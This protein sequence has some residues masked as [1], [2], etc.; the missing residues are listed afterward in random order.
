MAD[1]ITPLPT[2][3]A[4]CEVCGPC[5]KDKP[6]NVLTKLHGSSEQPRGYITSNVHLFLLMKCSHLRC[7]QIKRFFHLK[8]RKRDQ[9]KASK[10]RSLREGHPAQQD[11]K[12]DQVY[13]ERGLNIS[14]VA[15]DLCN[16]NE[17]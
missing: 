5:L 8:S 6:V 11:M 10:T 15:S 16:A 13:S 17:N 7:H 2:E 3:E 1:K 4:L 14:A 12:R 9:L